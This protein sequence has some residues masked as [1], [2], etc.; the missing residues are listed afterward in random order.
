MSDM[1]TDNHMNSFSSF[2][3]VK[4]DYS[5]ECDMNDDNENNPCWNC[6]Y[7]LFPIGCIKVR[8]KYYES[9]CNW[10]S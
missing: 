1:C 10:F 3:D 9:I 5:N 4:H 8:S 2:S 6:S 7:F